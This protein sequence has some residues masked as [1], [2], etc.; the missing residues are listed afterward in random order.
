MDAAIFSHHGGM[1]RNSIKTGALWALIL[2]K[3]AMSLLRTNFFTALF[4]IIF[5]IGCVPQLQPV[6]R[7]P[8][9]SNE[10]LISP[11]EPHTFVSP[12]QDVPIPQ[13]LK[14]VPKETLIMENQGVRTGMA[15]YWSRIPLASLNVFFRGELKKNGWE[16]TVAF[17]SE[18]CTTLRALVPDPFGKPRCHRCAYR[19]LPQCLFHSL[20]KGI[21][22]NLCS[23]CRTSGLC[24]KIFA[25]WSPACQRQR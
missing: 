3:R 1:A 21:S 25:L 19:G 5:S 20:G 23:G 6:E 14:E 16:Q 4:I 15:T 8:Q 18:P 2:E 12:F 22:G 10:P 9:F 24:T 17:T 11:Q 13:D 7:S